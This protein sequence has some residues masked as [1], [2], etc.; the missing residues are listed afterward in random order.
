MRLLNVNISIRKDLF[1]LDS[2]FGIPVHFSCP[3][4]GRFA[5][6]S[7]ASRVDVRRFEEGFV[8]IEEMSDNLESCFF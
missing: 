1:R 2:N 5:F 7:N 4:G 6:A 8:R 3:Y